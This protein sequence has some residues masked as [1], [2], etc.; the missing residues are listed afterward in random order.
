M[1][2][3][4][5]DISIKE[6]KNALKLGEI[7]IGAAIIDPKTNEIITSNHNRTKLD[8][9]PL[10]HAEILVIREAC[11]K[12]GIS[13]LDGYD[14]YS[15]LEPCAMCAAAISNAR[16]KRLY[17]ATTDDKYG[18]VVSNVNYFETKA[19]HHKVEYYYGFQ[20][21]IVQ[22]LLKEFFATKREERTGG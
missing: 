9:D 16:I 20:E 6:A 21:E 15:S 17:F 13:R 11:R 22:D 12:L 14:L 8:N 5:I 19:C 7:P 1:F 18:G 2:K 10:A 4:H 3:N